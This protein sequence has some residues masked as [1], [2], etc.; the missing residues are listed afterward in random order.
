MS[1]DI[2]NAVPMVALAGELTITSTTC[3]SA[4]GGGVGVATCVGGASVGVAVGSGVAVGVAVAVA[5]GSAVGIAEGVASGVAVGV[6]SA[7]GS[8]VAVAVAS[9]TGV[10]VSAS[11][12]Q[13]RCSCFSVRYAECSVACGAP[14]SA[15]ALSSPTL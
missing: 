10:G 11:P 8:A 14:F 4:P 9:A 1:A 2:M 12:L 5:V 13:P 7:M 15:F 6:G 3:T